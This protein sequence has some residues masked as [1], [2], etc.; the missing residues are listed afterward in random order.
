MAQHGWHV[1]KV[2]ESDEAPEFAYSI[3]LTESFE[4]PE[5]II[6]GL[7]LDV[8]HSALNTAGETIRA[9]AGYAPGA[10]SDAFLVD[11]RCTFRPFPSAESSKYLGRAI[12]FYGDRAFATL[13]LIW[14]DENARWPWDSA[15]NPSMREAQPIIGEQVN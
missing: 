15:A 1:I 11:R 5:L 4:H 14:S 13:Q 9:G 2:M 10:C 6:L 12:W 8:A 3:G 7:P